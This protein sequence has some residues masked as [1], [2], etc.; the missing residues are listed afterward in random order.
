MLWHCIDNNLQDNQNRSRKIR[1]TAI[2]TIQVRDDYSSDNKDSRW[3]CEKVVEFWFYF[4]CKTNK[5]S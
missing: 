3:R 4:E 1:S 2:E 5:V